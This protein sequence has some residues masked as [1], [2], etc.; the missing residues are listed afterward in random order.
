M[1]ALPLGASCR[2]QQ[3]SETGHHGGREHD[4]GVAYLGSPGSSSSVLLP[5]AVGVSDARCRLG[6]RFPR[7]LELRDGK[8]SPGVF[9]PSGSDTDCTY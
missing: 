4:L 3:S 7:N 9:V 2:V 1:T 8:A 5:R 6:E